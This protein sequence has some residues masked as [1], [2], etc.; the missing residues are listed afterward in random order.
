[1]LPFRERYLDEFIRHDGWT[2]DSKACAHCAHFEASYRCLECV[3]LS[4]VCADC[5]LKSHLHLPLHRIEKW[6]GWFWMSA[7]LAELGLTIQLGHEG[8]S[9]NDAMVPKIPLTVVHT[10]GVHAVRVSFCRCGHAPSGHYYS[11]QLLRVRWFPAT[12]LR[13]ATVFT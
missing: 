3:G 7:S 4:S 5:M 8:K 6:S 2:S 9:C 1:W 12:M 13:P 10:N 11:T